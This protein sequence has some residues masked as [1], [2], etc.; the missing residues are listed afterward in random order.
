MFTC[1]SLVMLAKI[2]HGLTQLLQLFSAVEELT[3]TQ[4]CHNFPKFLVN[5]LTFLIFCSSHPTGKFYMAQDG[6]FYALACVQ[7]MCTIFLSK[8]KL[9]EIVTSSDSWRFKFRIGLGFF[10]ARCGK[11]ISIHFPHRRWQFWTDTYCYAQR[12]NYF[13]CAHKIHAHMRTPF[14]LRLSYYRNLRF[15]LNM[16]QI[17]KS[18]FHQSCTHFSRQ[19]WQITW[20][21]YLK[22]IVQYSMEL[23]R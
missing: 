13:L 20:Q 19:R 11:K 15:Q 6:T 12:N 22:T 2:S 10:W 14:L 21:T 3:S 5:I 9:C 4:D 18:N 7:Y 8:W 23:F 17:K 1:F 16:K